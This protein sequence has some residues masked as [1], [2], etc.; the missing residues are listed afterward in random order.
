MYSQL[1]EV[2][3]FAQAVDRVTSVSNEPRR[4]YSGFEEQ[5]GNIVD[6]EIGR[7]IDVERDAYRVQ[8]FLL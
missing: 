8:S 3:V 7:P 4:S 6:H 2:A 1:E 5:V